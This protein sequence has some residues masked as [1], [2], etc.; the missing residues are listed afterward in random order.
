[1]G[2]DA[3]NKYPPEVTRRWGETMKMD[4]ATVELVDRKWKEYGF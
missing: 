2:I 4:K 3:T 1:M